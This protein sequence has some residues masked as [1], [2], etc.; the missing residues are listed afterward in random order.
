MES[1]ESSRNASRRVRTTWKCVGL[2]ACCILLYWL[3]TFAFRTPEREADAVRRQF[4]SAARTV[5]SGH[6]SFDL[7]AVSQ[8]AAIDRQ[9]ENLEP[10]D[11]GWDSEA[12]SAAISKQLKRLSQAFESNAPRTKRDFSDIAAEEFD[13]E[14][15]PE[16]ALRTIFDN[17]SCQ[18]QRLPNGYADYR[19]TDSFRAQINSLLE[20]EKPGELRCSFKVTHIELN[21]QAA[22]SRVLF[23]SVRKTD[24]TVVQSTADFQCQWQLDTT[25]PKLRSLKILGFEKVRFSAGGRLLFEDVTAAVLGNGS[26]DDTHAF[27]EQVLRD[28]GYWSERLSAID[29]MSIYGHHGLATGDVNQDGLDDIYVCDSGGLPNRL[30]LQQPDGTLQDASRKSRTDWLESTS[31]ALL[32]DLDNDG[33]PE[34][35]VAMVAGIVVASNN[36]AGVFDIRAAI[37]GIREAQSLCAADYDNDGDLDIYVTIY[38]AGG[39]VQ[40]QRGYE[41]APPLPYHD[42]NNGGRNVLFENRGAFQFVDVTTQ[43]GLDSNNKRFSFAASWEDFDVDGDMDLYVANDFGRNNLY[44]NDHGVFRD[45][46]ADLRVEDMAGGMS[47]SWGDCNQ[48]GLMDI[49]IGNMYSAAGKRVTYQRRFLDGRTPGS[50]SGIRRMARGNSLFISGED[51]VFTDVSET[52]QVTMGRW[53]WSS[54]FADL[55]NDGRE[56]LVVANGYFTNIK[57]DDL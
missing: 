22:T 13:G 26:E 42:A 49:Y 36:G 15:L 53:A 39:S 54:N 37:P 17:G 35:V 21:E 29:D 47:V 9:L 44:E 8:T 28:V 10:S 24:S 5:S 30:Y 7:P 57:P 3:L 25:E 43:C 1:M 50:S 6:S 40:G 48:D 27:N 4:Q 16:G 32:I 55:N 14:I 11:A 2:V 23:E 56:D 19:S 18:A 46:A 51:G 33:D 52:A 31:S 38:G 45:V 41:A 12:A 34:L 20:V